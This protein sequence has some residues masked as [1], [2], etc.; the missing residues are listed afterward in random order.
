M[1]FINRKEVNY[2]LYYKNTF[3]RILINKKN[4][5]NKYILNKKPKIVMFF[6]FKRIKEEN[7]DYI[8]LYNHCIFF[9]LITG[10]KGNVKNLDSVLDRGI[11]YYRYIYYCNINS[12][13]KFMNF[14]NETFYYLIQSN[15]IHKYLR[16][17]KIF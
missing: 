14:L 5:S 6:W 12:F 15:T 2:E 9:W 16:T 8:K 10:E 7:I 11:R 3:I 1:L 4:Y 17:K 13:F